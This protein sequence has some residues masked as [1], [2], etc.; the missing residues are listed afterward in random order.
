MGSVEEEEEIQPPEPTGPT[1]MQ[2]WNEQWQDVLKERKDE[3]NKTKAEHVEAA[4]A[5]TDEFNAQREQKRESRMSKNR[6]DE[7]EKLEAIEA[8]LE[9][10][11]SWQCVGKMVELSHDSTDGSANIGRMTETLILL[12]N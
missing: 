8:D 7:Q 2:I 6:A 3:E 11:N 5:S 4:R 12:K 10:D 1:P 9:S